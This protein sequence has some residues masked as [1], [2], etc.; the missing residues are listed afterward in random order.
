MRNSKTFLLLGGV[1]LS[2]TVPTGAAHAAVPI[3]P[4][5]AP[6]TTATYICD[7]IN[8]VQPGVFGYT[9]CEAF[10][11]MTKS[12]FIP[13][14]LSYMLIPRTGDIQKYRCSGG[15]VDVPTSV[16]PARCSAVGPS[17]PAAE[18]P[19]PVPYGGPGG[20]TR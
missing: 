20:V 2:L 18:A 9:N 12:G 7:N 17:I 4:P 5:P 3:P 19:P 13:N 11:G 1:V 10:G 6:P 8:A 16:A 14:G 15:N